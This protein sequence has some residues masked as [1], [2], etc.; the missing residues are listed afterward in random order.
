MAGIRNGRKG[1]KSGALLFFFFI[2]NRMPAIMR[3]CNYKGNINFHSLLLSLFLPRLPA[4]P[5]QHQNIV[6]TLPQPVQMLLCQASLCHLDPVPSPEI[7]ADVISP[8]SIYPHLQREVC[9]EKRSVAKRFRKFTSPSPGTRREVLL[10]GKNVPLG[11]YV[12]VQFC[13]WFNVVDYRAF[14]SKKK[15]RKLRQFS[16]DCSHFFLAALIR[17]WA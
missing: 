6:P 12:V 1:I 11:V 8:R 16:P 5:C 3:G 15:I 7:P 4:F 2:P 13:P 10:R 17:A 14:K 9:S